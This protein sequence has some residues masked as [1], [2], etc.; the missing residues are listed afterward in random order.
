[1]WRSRGRVRGRVFEDEAAVAC[2]EGIA[3][4][5]DKGVKQLARGKRDEKPAAEP[6]GLPCEVAQRGEVRVERLE[7]A[8]EG[9]YGEGNAS[10]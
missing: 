4:V 10:L 5:K 2:G 9:I 1:M 8:A 7:R 3:A 6:G